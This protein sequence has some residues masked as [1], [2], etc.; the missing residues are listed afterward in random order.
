MAKKSGKKRPRKKQRYVTMYVQE[1]FRDEVILP[2]LSMFAMCDDV[3]TEDDALIDPTKAKM[4]LG[5]IYEEWKRCRTKL[6]PGFVHEPDVRPD[7]FVPRMA[8]QERR[9]RRA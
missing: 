3:F 2:L 4:G 1:D 8:K 5:R 6:D 7:K 9:S